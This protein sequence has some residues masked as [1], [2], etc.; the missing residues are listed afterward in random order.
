MSKAK[1]SK[2]KQSRRNS[3]VEL[4][5]LLALFIIVISHSLPRYGTS[6]YTVD[7][8]YARVNLDYVLTIVEYY[9]GQIGNAIFIACSS[10]FLLEHNKIRSDKVRMIV[11]DSFIISVAYVTLFLLLG[12]KLDAKT[13]VKQ[14]FP[15]IFENNWF[16]S[17]YLI[18]YITHG[19]LN[20]LIEAMDKME[21]LNIVLGCV[22]LYGILE[23]VV[24]SDY[25]YCDL[26]GF[27]TIYLL[28]GYIKKYNRKEYDWSRIFATAFVAL[29]IEIIVTNYCGT[30]FDAFSDKVLRWCRFNNIVIIVIAISLLFIALRFSFY[31][32]SLNYASSMSLLIYLIHENDLL[33]MYIK[34]AIWKVICENLNN[35]YL[36]FYTLVFAIILFLV[37]GLIAVIY[38]KSIRKWG[39]IISKWAF[40]RLHMIYEHIMSVVYNL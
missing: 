24:S 36:A 37:S 13:I 34:P 33:S 8:N 26:L 27:F 6:Q 2:A 9:F 11:T 1:Q 16:V 21:H 10:W 23:I 40:T 28:V 14:F 22:F 15:I 4:L 20:R 12:I 18:M 31:S 32:K 38:K 7:F 3:S 39:D 35:S 25:R 17:C 5:K 29:L 19:T 30:I